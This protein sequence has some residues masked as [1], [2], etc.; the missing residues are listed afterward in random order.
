MW[1]VG[2][3]IHAEQWAAAQGSGMIS[4][5]RQWCHPS[6]HCRSAFRSLVE[7]PDADARQLLYEHRHQQKAHVGAE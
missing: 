5:L 3:K 2:A 6:R 4:G 1:A 7:P